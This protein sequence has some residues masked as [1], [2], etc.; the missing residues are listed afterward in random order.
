MRPAAAELGVID[1]AFASRHDR[2]AVV[3]AFYP[4][5]RR[6]GMAFGPRRGSAL[7]R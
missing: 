7:A 5:P 4:R 3:G 1:L 6:T 2:T